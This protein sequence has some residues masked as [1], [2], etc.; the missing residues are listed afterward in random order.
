MAEDI[1][2]PAEEIDENQ[3]PF[4]VSADGTSS[5]EAQIGVG[6]SKDHF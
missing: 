6:N 1:D 4:G 5:G 2:E 3:M